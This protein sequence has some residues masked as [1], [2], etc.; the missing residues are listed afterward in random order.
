MA[1]S[2]SITDGWLYLHDGSDGF[3]L[4]VETITMDWKFNPKI[5][6]YAGKT[7][8]FYNLE[9][10]WYE[11]KCKN[12][13][14]TSHTNFSSVMDQLKDWMA[15]SQELTFLTQRNSGGNYIEWD[16]DNTSYTVAI[17]KDGLKGAEKISPGD[18]DVY[19][20]G[21]LILEQVG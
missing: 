7:H 18:G 2:Y 16:G 21:L 14:L 9:K 19:V 15:D 20:I 11:W 4:Y 6:H 13:Y 8:L 5:S 12:I 1:V 10:E 3:K 17:A